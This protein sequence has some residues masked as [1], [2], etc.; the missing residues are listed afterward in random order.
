MSALTLLSMVGV[1]M[2]SG[3]GCDGL[4]CRAGRVDASIWYC[5]DNECAMSGLDTIGL[6]LGPRPL[7]CAFFG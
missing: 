3:Q 1:L 5:S 2:S 4:I 6:G 7:T